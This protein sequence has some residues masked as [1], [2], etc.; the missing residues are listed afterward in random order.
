MGLCRFTVV[1]G[2]DS[3]GSVEVYSYMGLEVVFCVDIHRHGLG[4]CEC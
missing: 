4:R 1:G 3:A 2:L